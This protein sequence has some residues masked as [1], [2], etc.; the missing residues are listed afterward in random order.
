MEFCCQGKTAK[1][2]RLKYP[3]P[4]PPAHL[5]VPP[6]PRTQSRLGLPPVPSPPQAM[7]PTRRKNQYCPR[8][9]ARNENSPESLGLLAHRAE[10]HPRPQSPFRLARPPFFRRQFPWQG[11]DFSCP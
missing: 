6:R 4:P 11:C 1:I 7:S 9:A 5:A 3:S 2:S 10:P 8:E